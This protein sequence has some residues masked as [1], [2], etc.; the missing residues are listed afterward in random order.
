MV[1]EGPFQI[2]LTHIYTFFS[3]ANNY[4]L[5]VIYIKLIN[6]YSLSVLITRIKN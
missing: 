6:H 4:M 5:K 2:K 1:Y 3:D